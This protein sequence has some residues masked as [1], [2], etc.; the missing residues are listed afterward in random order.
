MKIDTQ[1][2]WG[3]FEILVMTAGSCMVNTIA[4]IMSECRREF[5]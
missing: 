4:S 5:H 2:F 3:G 1:I